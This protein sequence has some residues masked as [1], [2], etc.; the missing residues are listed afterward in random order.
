MK[1]SA[2]LGFLWRDRGLAEAIHAAHA[3]GFDAVEC[4]W[5]YDQPQAEVRTALEATGLPM[6]GLNTW[7][8]DVAAGEFGL[9]ALPGREEDARDAITQALDWAEALG[10]GS[11]HVMAGKSSDPM[12]A[13]VFRGNLRFACERA[14]E[15]GKTILLEPLNRHDAPGY[16][17]ST[18]DQAA[19][20][21]SELGFDNL[22]LM[23]DC[24]HVQRSEGDVVTRLEAL[25]PIIGHIQIAASPD[26]GTPDHGELF[27]PFVYQTIDRLGYSAPIGAEYKPLGDTEDSL[28]WLRALKG[29]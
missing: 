16:V 24:Y 2:N 14:A 4:H 8:G 3:A 20:I 12:A 9:C 6:L 22:K 1:F 10:A 23:F 7:P 29:D 21:I 17:L 25:L 5:P 27:Y 13:S 18:T 15:L 11:V 19:E 28:D 26:R